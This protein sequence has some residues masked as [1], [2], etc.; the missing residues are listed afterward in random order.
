MSRPGLLVVS[1]VAPWPVRGGFSL[2]AAH[3][4]EE[5]AADWDI[6][7]VV[8]AEMSADLVP[9]PKSERNDVIAVP[10]ST[11]WT[12]SPSA[13]ADFRPLRQAVESV[14]RTRR[15]D[16]ALLFNGAEFL[17]FGR[18]GF[19]STVA[20]RIDCGALE[21][22][23]YIRRARFLRPLKAVYETLAE[24]RYERRLVREVAATTVVG[25]DDAGALRRISGRDTVHVV[26]N[27]V[28]A[29]DYPAF[30]SESET[31][32]VVFTGTLSY[33]A[34]ADAVRFLVNKL[35]PSIRAR[36]EDAR[37][38]VAGRAPGKGITALSTHPGVEVRPNVPDMVSV[39]RESWVTVAPM[40]CG[41]GVKNKVLEAWAVGRPAIMTPIGANGLRLD[42][43]ARELVT[44]NPSKF[45]DLV[46][47]LLRDQKLRHRYGTAAQDL[48]RARHTWRE[49][50]QAISE[51]LQAV[52][53]RGRSRTLV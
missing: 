20:D 34:N 41:A 26:P 15:P 10:L 35:W 3:L 25:E 40:R 51:L 8:A 18:E 5:L 29:F 49:S 14:I 13:R 2:R 48:A 30:D 28:H 24:T 46:V 33:Y 32:T 39:L 9:W 23:R 43:T 17:A 44:A 4:L 1:G 45:G 16:A 31:P 36:V 19:P 37:L 12:P 47:S 50:A 27:G 42:T 21:R 7:L 11:P 6:T 52:T 22:F 53:N 38:I